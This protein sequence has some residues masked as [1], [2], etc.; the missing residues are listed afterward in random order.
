MKTVELTDATASLA[1]YAKKAG[2]SAVVVTDK[3][4]P[5]AALVG[6]A[7]ADWEAISLSTN[8]KFLAIIERSRQRYRREGGLTE[9]QVRERLDIPAK[10]KRRGAR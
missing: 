5:I 9:E 3:G 4:R 7:D 10:R 1:N 2:K 6:I 8:P